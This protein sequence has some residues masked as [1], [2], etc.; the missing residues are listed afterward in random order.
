MLRDRQ[1]IENRPSFFFSEKE[2]LKINNNNLVCGD[3]DW[4]KG[5]N[6]KEF[7]SMKNVFVSRLHVTQF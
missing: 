3:M 5:K 6:T 1:G 2:N 7:R 4:K